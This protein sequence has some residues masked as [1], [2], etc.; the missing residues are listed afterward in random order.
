MMENAADITLIV[1]CGAPLRPGSERRPKW[2]LTTPQGQLLAARAAETVPRARVMRTIVVFLGEVE[3]RYGA[4]AA[5]RRAFDREIECVLLDAPTSGPAATVRAAIE[6]AGVSGPVCI[7]DSD[8]FFSLRGGL[9]EG[10]FLAIADVRTMASLSEPARKS[11]VRLNEQEL[12][13]DI[14][15]KNV[16]SN[17]ISVGLY[18]FADTALFCEAYD[19]L[20]ALTGGAQG[21]VSHVIKVA[22]VGGHIFQ[23]IHTHDLVDIGT[24]SDWNAYRS[25]LPSIVLDIDGVVFRN[26]SEFFPPYWSD[27]VEPIEP[28]VA[29]IRSLQARGAQLIFMTA[30]PEAYRA[31]TLAA[32]ERIGLSVH[33]LVMGCHHGTRYLVNDYAGSNPY[34]SAIAINLPRN[35]DSLRDI[36]LE[37][38]R[39]LDREP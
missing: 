21:F 33:A 20:M 5:L 24:R 31:A 35:A 9:P 26:Q 34:P 38:H 13:V 3:E 23:P 29:H 10:S 15:E 11:Y 7:K 6:Q 18:G 1:P 17:F 14:V 30:R 4:T 22:I 39:A 32:L 25:R 36:L 2:L 12:V 8:S 28:N 37:D 27:P 19:S 16:V